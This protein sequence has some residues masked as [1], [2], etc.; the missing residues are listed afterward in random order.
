VVG[1]YRDVEVDRA[2][3]LSASLAELHRLPSYRRLPLHGLTR[4]EVHRLYCLAR[5]QEVPRSRTEAVYRRTEGNPLFVQEILRYLVDAGMVVRQGDR[6]VRTDDGSPDAGIPEG[7]RDVVGKRLSHLSAECNRLLAIAAIIG[8]ELDLAVLQDVAGMDEESVTTALEEAIRAGILEERFRPGAIRYRFAHAFFRQTLYEELIAPRRLRLH[9]QVGRAVEARY[10]GRLD[11]H[12]SE[13]AEHFAH[14]T[15]AGDLAKAINYGERAARLALSV[16]AYG[17]AARI[18]GQTLQVL[19]VL[20]PDDQLH[21][22]DVLLQ[23]GEAL[24]PAGEARRAAEEVAP[25]A[26]ALA[27][28]L[29]DDRRASRACQL[30]LEGFVRYGGAPV[31]RSPMFRD[32]AERADRYAAPNSTERVYADHAL[33]NHKTLVGQEHEAAMLLQGAL[34]LA[35]NLADPEAQFRSAWKFLLCAAGPRRHPQRVRVAAEFITYPR[36]GVNHRTLGTFLWYAAVVYLDC[37][38]RQQFERLAGE[39]AT[40]AERTQ[41]PA[42]L[43]RPLVFAVIR[44][45]LDGE[46]ERSLEAARELIARADQLG[47]GVLGRTQAYHWAAR[48]RLYSGLLDDSEADAFLQMHGGKPAILPLLVQGGDGEAVERALQ[49]LLAESHV[50][51][52]GD[53]TRTPF[54][55]GCLEAAAML[56]NREL[57]EPL[58]RQLAP[59]ADCVSGMWALTSIARLLGSAAVA[60]GDGQAAHDYYGRAL[61]GLTRLRYR[62]EIAVVHLQLA[63]LLVDEDLTA[64]LA[65]LEVATPELAAMHMRP[66]LERAQRLQERAEELRHRAAVEPLSPRERE[67][68]A[69]L[70]RG[71][72]N[73]SIAEALVITEATTGVHVKHILGK[74]GFQSRSQVAVWA[75]ARGLAS[76]SYPRE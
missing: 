44:H 29:G 24:I 55:A 62:P 35:R 46:L 5:G 52:D 75:A 8:R 28:Q 71:L 33:G 76:E 21:A 50:G 58:A 53:E 14:S 6:F 36:Q 42:L 26:L 54:Y 16:N 31:E 61:E 12:A 30:A 51:T 17:E 7:L 37:G 72:S 67:V 41:D 57:V 1:T 32:W 38:D 59:A 47:M 15:D 73:R 3:P 9:Q 25:Q 70:A 22:C 19:D 34:A 13:L 23:L 49:R 45:T 18:L 56:G 27:E 63:E 39:V 68:A 40:I 65:H 2:H 69:L 48:A 11:E 64:A 4:D 74:L 60:C 66:F 20:D 43:W 10:A